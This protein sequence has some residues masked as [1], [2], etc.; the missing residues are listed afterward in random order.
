M[1]ILP[2]GIHTLTHA[3]THIYTHTNPSSTPHHQP[4]LAGRRKERER[5]AR[6]G[7]EPEKTALKK[8]RKG[9]REWFFV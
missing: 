2:S 7:G 4:F 5:E 9:A 3:H 1:E 6:V 8:G